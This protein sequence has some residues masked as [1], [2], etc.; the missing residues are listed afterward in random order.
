M[1]LLQRNVER[2]GV[3]HPKMHLARGNVFLE[4]SSGETSGGHAENASGREAIL[5]CQRKSATLTA[6]W[7]TRAIKAKEKQM[8]VRCCVVNKVLLTVLLFFSVTR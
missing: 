8:C 4:K 6:K 5:N 1:P 2:R 3:K 7:K